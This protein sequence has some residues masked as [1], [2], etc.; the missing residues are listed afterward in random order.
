MANDDKM[1][2]LFAIQN[3]QNQINFQPNPRTVNNNIINSFELTDSAFIK[4]YRLTKNLANTL[5]Q[6]L[7]PFLKSPKRAI[8]HFLFIYYIFYIPV[9]MLLYT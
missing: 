4:N 1:A 7:S 2:Y 3:Q 5:I 9:P 8:T 6:E